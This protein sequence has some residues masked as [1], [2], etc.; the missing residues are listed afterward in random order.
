LAQTGSI[1]H[2]DAFIAALSDPVLE[3]RDLAAQALASLD[4]GIVFEKIMA[5]LGS[6]TGDAVVKIDAVLPGLRDSLETGMLRVLDAPDEPGARKQVAAY[7]LGRMNS[8][9]AVPALM[10]AVWVAEPDVAVACAQALVAIRDPMIGPALADLI[11]HPVQPVRWVA[12][13]G[14][15]DLGSPESLEALH[16][17]A[18]EPPDGDT[19]LGRQAVSYLAATRNEMVV[20]LLIEVMRGN[21]SLRRAAVE[22]L[23][24]LTG[25]DLGDRPSDWQAWYEQKQQEAQRPPDELPPEA[26]GPP[27]WEIEYLPE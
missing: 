20:P 14:L 23:R 6:G 18:V 9:R 13:Q 1:E 11:R 17:V 21:L 2:V 15:A 22:A 24:Q 12:L 8:V 25:E 7:A 19:E 16:R 26:F 10:A 27:P 3:I 5:I 4:S